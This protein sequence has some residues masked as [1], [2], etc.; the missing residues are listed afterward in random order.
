MKYRK[1]IVLSASLIAGFCLAC[2]NAAFGADTTG[3]TSQQ[4]SAP[5]AATSAGAPAAAS[6]QPGSTPKKQTESEK[7]MQLGTV[8]VAG[9]RASLAASLETKRTADAVVDAITAE[10]VGKFPTTNV[11]EALALIPGITLDNAM[12]ASQRVSVDGLDPS[13]NVSLL[14]GHPVAQ[15]MWLFGDSPNRGFNFS[16]LPSELVGKVEVYKSPEARLPEGSLGGT[17]IMHT[18]DPLSL[19]TNTIAGSI[20]FNN[21]SL[22]SQ[23]KPIASGF[24]SFKN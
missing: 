17:I 10:D 13:L 18:A 4:T 15:A 2:V 19:K 23:S 14:D 12:P 22:V 24:Y 1:N 5:A 11:A 21:N 20:G 3:D 8:S 7:E 6:E 16:L 9:I